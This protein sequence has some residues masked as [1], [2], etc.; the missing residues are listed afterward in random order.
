MLGLL[1]ALVLT[2]GGAP[3]VGPTVGETPEPTPFPDEVIIRP[4][5]SHAAPPAFAPTAEVALSFDHPDPD[6]PGPTTTSV[7]VW[8]GAAFHPAPDLLSPFAALGVEA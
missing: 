3:V 8:L 5:I 1:L 4:K 7:P 2:S 6:H